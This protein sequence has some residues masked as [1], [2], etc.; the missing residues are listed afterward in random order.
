MRVCGPWLGQ[1][2]IVHDIRERW[3]L[4]R[5]DDIDQ[6]RAIGLDRREGGGVALEDAPGMVDRWIAPSLV[7]AEEV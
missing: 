3:G 4:W 5:C 1:H 2:D 6:L 7:A